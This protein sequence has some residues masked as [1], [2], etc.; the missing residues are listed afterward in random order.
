MSISFENK[1][2]QILSEYQMF[3]NEYFEQAKMMAPMVIGPYIEILKAID[4]G[5]YHF[6]HMIPRARVYVE[7]GI[8]LPNL[9]IFLN[10][11]VLNQ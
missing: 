3:M 8:V 7:V 10:D 4:L 2:Q 1:A 5:N 11:R 6:F 9:N